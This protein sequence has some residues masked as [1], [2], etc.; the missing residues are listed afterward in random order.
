M[1]GVVCTQASTPLPEDTVVEVVP[2]RDFVSRGGRKLDAALDS[3]DVQVRG[4]VVVDIGSSTGGF[5]D[6]VLQRGAQKVVA[7]DVGLDQLDGR[8]R[9]DPRVEVREGINARDLEA[10]DFR[11][12]PE[13]VVVD[14][15]FISLSKLASALARILPTGG[16]LVALVKPQFEV[17]PAVARKHRGVVRN[18]ADRERGIV[19]ARRSLEEAGFRIRG[20]CDS[21]VRGKSGNVERFLHAIRV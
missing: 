3:L 21:A 19:S 16:E 13:L 7:V 6:C 5:T 17:G 9:E 14:A 2:G 4:R 12:P 15:S 1:G 10:G 20:E 8:L 11:D 18:R